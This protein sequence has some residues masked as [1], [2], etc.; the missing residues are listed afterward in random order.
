MINKVILMGRLTRDP[1]I[2]HTGTGRAV[3]NF[4][5]AVDN[6]YG[7]NRQTDFINCV[8]WNNQ[9]DFMEK[10]FTKGMMI[11][12]SGRISTRTWEGQ[13][14]KKNYVTEVIVNE[15]NFGETKRA[16]NENAGFDG[17]YNAPQQ[18]GQAPSYSAPV[19]DA[20]PQAM[21]FGVEGEEFSSL[22]EIDD[23]LPF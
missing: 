2:R 21:P 5:I 23:D 16:R 13:D 14:G 1:E 12:A 8:A 7:Q 6:G 3:C 20:A 4:T 10:Y 17:G 15:V 19:Q 18:S 22:A 11:I 9:A